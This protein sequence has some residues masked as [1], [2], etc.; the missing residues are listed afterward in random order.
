MHLVKIDTVNASDKNN[1]CPMTW[2]E[3]SLC[4]FSLEHG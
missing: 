3:L 4:Q 2:E 1:Q